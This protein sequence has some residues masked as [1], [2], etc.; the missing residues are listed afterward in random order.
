M[1]LITGRS[2]VA[3]DALVTNDNIVMINFTESTAIGRHVS[4]IAEIKRL[5]LELGGK[6]YAL[7]LEDADLDQTA[8]C[9]LGSKKVF[10]AEV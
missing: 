1:N 2:D 9:V 3:G 4:K 6:A 7:V 8:Q 10:R 5:H